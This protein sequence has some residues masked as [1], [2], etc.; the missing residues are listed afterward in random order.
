MTRGQPSLSLRIDWISEEEVKQHG[1]RTY[2]KP[3][4]HWSTATKR[5]T[6]QR[7]LNSAF[8]NSELCSF[9]DFVNQGTLF[10]D[11]VINKTTRTSPDCRT[12]NKIDCITIGQK[13]RRSLRDVRVNRG[14]DAVIKKKLKAYNDQAGKHHINILYTACRSNKGKFNVQFRN[15]LSVI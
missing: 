14:V 5:R 9:N 11:E 4:C 7:I 13:W 10:P 6:I 1:Q 12:N 2:Q 3:A 8:Q 15:K